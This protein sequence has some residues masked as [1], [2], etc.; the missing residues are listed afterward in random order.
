MTDDERTVWNRACYFGIKKTDGLKEGDVALG[1]LLLAHNYIC[2][3][4]VYHGIVECLSSDQFK[5]A[6]KGYRYFGFSGTA[7]LLEKAR[8]EFNEFDES[9]GD[10]D[11][12]LNKIY[13]TTTTDK[14]ITERFNEHFKKHRELYAP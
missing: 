10:K 9:I 14:E 2:N 8:N 11:N 6:C 13:Y 5:E 3:G 12:K 1:A 7:D 4:G